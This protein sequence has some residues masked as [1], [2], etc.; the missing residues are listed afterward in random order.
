MID[1]AIRSVRLGIMPNSKGKF[2]LKI[3]E[4]KQ[5]LAQLYDNLFSTVGFDFKNYDSILISPDGALNTLPFEIL[6]N[7]NKNKYLI[8]EKKI[9]YIPSG[10]ELVRLNKNMYDSNSSGFVM[11][12]NP[13]FNTKDAGQKRSSY[14][15]NKKEKLSR[16][17]SDN[18]VTF[19]MRNIRFGSLPGTIEE[20]KAIEQIINSDIK[21]YT[22]SNATE[23]NLLNINSPKEL[24]IATHGFFLSKKPITNPLLK[25]GLALS[26]ANEAIK[27]GKEEGVVTG[28]EISAMDLRN[29]DMVVLSACETGLGEISD[30]EGVAGLNQAFF[31]AGANSVVMSLWQV[32]DAETS[33]LMQSFYKNYKDKEKPIVSLQKAKLDMIN[34]EL[35]PYYWGA[36]ILSGAD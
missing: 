28:L 25:A 36:F 2:P 23:S 17:M 13:D 21:L 20:A 10:R 1:K 8:E 4:L 30:G 33:K 3:E 32:P 16:G 34:K 26:G 31:R 24:H 27:K 14:T 5:Q 15:I 6:Y 19:H 18:F 11:F 7:K 35:H 9:K 29:T 12:A 22:E